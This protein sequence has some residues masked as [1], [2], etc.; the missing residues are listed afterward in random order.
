MSPVFPVKYGCLSDHL[1]P[2]VFTFHS[3]P[4][5]AV[6][7][8]LPEE[9][10]HCALPSIWLVISRSG[11]LG[12]DYV[13]LGSFTRSDYPGVLSGNELLPPGPLPP[14]CSTFFPTF[15]SFFNL[16]SSILS[17]PLQHSP[18]FLDLITSP[19]HFY[20]IDQYVGR[21]LCAYLWLYERS[22]SECSPGL[23]ESGISWDER[24]KVH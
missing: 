15:F 16:C 11:A 7:P 22:V 9:G 13:G 6:A 1:R 19:L 24:R 4:L 17:E 10:A 23:Q 12:A 2:P 14:F 5:A 21:L 18:R 8:S 3:P 20:N